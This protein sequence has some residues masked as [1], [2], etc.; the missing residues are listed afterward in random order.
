MVL[1]AHTSRL[2]KER[3]EGVAVGLPPTPDVPKTDEVVRI[4]LKRDEEGRFRAV[5]NSAAIKVLAQ[6]KK[7]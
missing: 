1:Y 3:K 6:P 5:F 4:F 7:P 2:T